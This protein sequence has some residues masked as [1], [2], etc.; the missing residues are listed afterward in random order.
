MEFL[1]ANPLLVMM[2]LLIPVMFIA[3]SR[4]RKKLQEQQAEHQRQINEALQPGAWVLVSAGFW[5]RYVDTEG[6]VIV[7]ESPSGG[8]TYW[9]R[10]TVVKAGETPFAHLTEEEVEADEETEEPI[11]GV[12]SSF[13]DTSRN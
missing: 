4:G 8:E 9:Q 6:D 2:L 13:D 12:G 1:T 3:S 5:G 11:M 7:L 10:S